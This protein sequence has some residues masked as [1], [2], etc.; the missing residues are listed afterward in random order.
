MPANF[1]FSRLLAYSLL[2]IMTAVISAEV[3]VADLPRVPFERQQFRRPVAIAQLDA[4]TA[5]VA[6][7]CGTL[8]VIDLDQWQ[9]AAE[10]QIGGQLTNLAVTNGL[11]LVTDA[12]HSRLSLIRISRQNAQ[13]VSELPVP[14]HP[15]TVQVAPD[16][17]FCTVASKWA[18]KLT[19]VTLGDKL[20]ISATVDLGFCP[21]EQLH[22]PS[23]TSMLVADAFT[24]RL[25][26]VNT[27]THDVEAVHEFGAHNIRGLAISN[28]GQSL[29]ISHQILNDA[30]LPRRSDIVWGVMINNLL[31]TAKLD[32]VLE[33]QSGAIYGGQSINVGYAGQGAGD[34]DTLFVDQSGQAV[35]ALAGVNEVLIGKPGSR[36]FQRIGVGIRPIDLLPLSEGRF[37]VVNELS[38]SLTLID[39]T[40]DAASASATEAQ[41]ANAAKP[42]VKTVTVTAKTVTATTAAATTAAAK[43]DDSSPQGDGEYDEA[44]AYTRKYGDQSVY[45]AAASTYRSSYLE[46]DVFTSS[47]SLGPMPELG[48]AERGEQLFFSARLSHAS[49]FSCHSCHVEGHSNGGRSDTFGDDTEGAPKRV[50]SLLG[51][52][53][54]GPWGWNGKKPTLPKQ[55]HQSATSTMRGPGIS[56]SAA[57]DLAAFLTTLKPPPPFEPAVTPAD[58]TQI[59]DGRR[60]FE[61]LSCTECHSGTTL[62][63]ADAYDVGLVDER[64][65]RQFNPPSLRGVGYREKL[66]HDKRADSLGEVFT[67][68]EHQLARQLSAT[69]LSALLRYLRSL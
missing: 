52:G 35:I 27:T 14:T 39:M 65:L 31:R 51:V 10:Y 7:R 30:A 56:D 59:S 25:A 64:G 28:D 53:E 6:N 32:S 58:R 11:L 33:G 46:T 55:I 23:R 38:D 66:F 50:L 19:F 13:V 12:E 40:K 63:S 41:T 37:V 17:T 44:E 49:W 61:S 34:P 18:R 60:L 15:V 67:K 54:T 16:G 22:V 47:L 21:G 69:E 20:A 45:D 5:V 36:A 42:T 26:V 1:A 62:T 57:S 8:S 29:L 68:F 3:A 43:S 4:S 24:G 2:L 48:P 9:V